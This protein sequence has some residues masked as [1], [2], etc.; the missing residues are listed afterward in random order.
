MDL[1]ICLHHA[2]YNFSTTCFRVANCLHGFHDNWD[3]FIWDHLFETFHLRLRSFQ[4]CSFEMHWLETTFTFIW[5]LFILEHFRVRLVP[6]RPAHSFQNQL[7]QVDFR[8]HSFETGSCETALIWDLF[9][10]DHVHLGLV[11]LTKYLLPETCSFVTRYLLTGDLF[12]WDYV[13]FRPHSFEI[14]WF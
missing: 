8:L 9:I 3:M 2:C 13:N 1:V 11:H 10:W 7:R 12:M 5:G 4:T 14:C 6:W